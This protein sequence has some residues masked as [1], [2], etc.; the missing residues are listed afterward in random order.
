MSNVPDD[1]LLVGEGT[2]VIACNGEKI[3][4]IQAVTYD[5]NGTIRAVVV[6]AGI[7]QHHDVSVPA[8]RMESITPRQIRLHVTADD[9]AALIPSAVTPG[10]SS[11]GSAA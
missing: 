5:A 11:D 3:G 6:R 9:A 7:F 4:R 1:A 10:A 8:D 2:A